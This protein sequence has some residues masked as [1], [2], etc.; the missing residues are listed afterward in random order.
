MQSAGLFIILGLLVAQ[1]ALGAPTQQAMQFLE[2]MGSKYKNPT[3]YAVRLDSDVS[4]DCD[5]NERSVV[6][7]LWHRMRPS[8][9]FRQVPEQEGKVNKKK[10]GKFTVL[11]VTLEDIGFY[12]C[13][14]LSDS[15]QEITRDFVIV[16][17]AAS[18]SLVMSPE[19]LLERKVSG[20]DVRISCETTANK[21]I[22]WFYYS[23]NQDPSQKQRIRRSRNYHVTNVN[24]NV[25]YGF[26]NVT[27]WNSTLTIVNAQV[28][29]SGHY[30]CSLGKPFEY[31]YRNN[32]LVVT[33]P[34][35]PIFSTSSETITA[36]PN[37]P[38]FLGCK[39]NGYP[40]PT[41]EWKYFPRM[42]KGVSIKPCTRIHVER[43]TDED[44]IQA[45]DGIIVE[46]PDVD[47]HSGMFLC[48]SNNPFGTARKYFVVNVPH[49]PEI[50]RANTPK[51]ILRK[52]GPSTFTVYF[53]HLGYPEPSI[54]WEMQPSWFYGSPANPS[55]WRPFESYDKAVRPEVLKKPTE[56]SL[57]TVVRIPF[58]LNIG[59]WFKVTASNDEG[60]DSLEV[61]FIGQ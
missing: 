23:T 58:T 1:C 40:K 34:T 33:D 26:S 17:T 47:Y 29:Q 16:L 54:R 10:P 51:V 6:V 32:H 61:L 46:R 28:A 27:V 52:P 57:S 56:G 42:K 59:A 22:K 19:V 43:C 49:A 7:T 20:S 21:R 35:P 36:T 13:R 48:I 37:T 50:D 15:K 25:D 45:T 14:A 30:E 41:I 24:T 55:M 4:L 38:V 9:T 60:S 53:K 18:P 31:L 44:F 11:K 5:T 12:Q 8:D 39:P 3:V 2:A